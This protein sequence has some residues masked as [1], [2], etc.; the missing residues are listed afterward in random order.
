MTKYE[1]MTQEQKA[2]IDKLKD[3]LTEL[4]DKAFIG[5]TGTTTPDE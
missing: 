4:C 3:E 1:D 5:N 2:V